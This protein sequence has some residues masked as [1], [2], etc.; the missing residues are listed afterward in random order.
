MLSRLSLPMYEVKD[1]DRLPIPYR[2]VATDIETGKEVVLSRG[3]LGQ[4]IR[5]SMAVPA[6][7]D[8]AEIDGRLLVDGGLADDGP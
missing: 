3:S 6:A 4:A 8:P 7:F 5:A 2:A 1:F